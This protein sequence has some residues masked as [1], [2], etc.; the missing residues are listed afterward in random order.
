M[1]AKL[2]HLISRDI[3]QE[4]VHVVI[5]QRCSLFPACSR[6][7]VVHSRFLPPL[8]AMLP[9]P[10]CLTLITRQTGMETGSGHSLPACPNLALACLPEA[11]RRHPFSLV[12]TCTAKCGL[13]CW[14]WTIV[15]IGDGTKQHYVLLQTEKADRR[16]NFVSLALRKR[17]SYLTEPG[18]S[19]L[20]LTKY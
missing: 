17:Y 1:S 8:V 6:R 5:S 3:E 18:M 7:V 9:A 19:E 13:S 12:G 16:Q 15:Q 2:F 14:G 20:L 11:E 4:W 10:W